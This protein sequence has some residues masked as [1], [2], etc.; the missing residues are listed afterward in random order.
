VAQTKADPELLRQLEAAAAPDQEI[1]A[2]CSLRPARPHE[3][4]IPPAEAGAL[5]ERVLRRVQRQTGRRP[6]R[7]QVFR[8]L[9]SFAVSAPAAF[10]RQLL[11]QREIATA[12]ANRQPEDLLIRPV[13]SE[14]AE[15]PEEDA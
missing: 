5:V 1:A 3:K 10:L 4:F 2:V 9:G 11:Q 6:G 7:V 8:N 13:S 12:T 14:P 15:G